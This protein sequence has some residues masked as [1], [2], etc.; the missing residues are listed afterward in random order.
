MPMKPP[1]MMA[2]VIPTCGASLLGPSLT[3]P[4]IGKTL[5]LGTWQQVVYL[6]FD[7][8]PRHRE[9]VVQMLGE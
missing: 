1:G 2:T 7:V 5:T 9:L 6:D 8:R 3:I 4:F